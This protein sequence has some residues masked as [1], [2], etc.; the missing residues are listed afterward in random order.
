MAL[1]LRPIGDGDTI[2]VLREATLGRSQDLGASWVNDPEVSRQH[3]RLYEEMIDK[4]PRWL[5]EDLGSANGTFVNRERVIQRRW[6]KDEDEI[7]IGQSRFIVV[8]DQTYIWPGSGEQTPNFSP[9]PQGAFVL[10]PTRPHQAISRDQPERQGQSV[11]HL[12]WLELLGLVGLLGLGWIATGK[13]AIGGMWLLLGGVVV[14][15]TVLLA[16]LWEETFVW[17]GGG[18]LLIFLTAISLGMLVRRDN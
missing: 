11:S 14:L 1:K 12:V 2:V 18:G 9:A 7:R 3:A 17:L 16:L 13:Q 8:I 15:M 6:L 10:D 5:I 4:K